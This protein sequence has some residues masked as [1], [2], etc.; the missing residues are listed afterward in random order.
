VDSGA[1][2]GDD[3]E[4]FQEVKVMNM[5]KAL[6]LTTIVFFVAVVSRSAEQVKDIAGWSNTHWGM[7]FDQAK[8]VRPDLTAGQTAYGTPAGR[9]PDVTLSSATFRVYL[10]FEE[11]AL[12]GDS[13]LRRVEL[14]GPV[15][16]CYSI[17][18]AL[19]AKYGQPTT[20]ERDGLTSG[21]YRPR[22]F[23]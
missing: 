4:S 5:R 22:R 11:G 21:H 2:L 17:A 7:T 15:D 9:L 18:E 16:A 8:A 6:Y 10:Q 20:R 3:Q 12:K 14:V 13:R 19:A 1:D 23:V